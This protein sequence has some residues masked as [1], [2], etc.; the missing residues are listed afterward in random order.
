[1]WLLFV[2]YHLSFSDYIERKLFRFSAWSWMCAVRKS[3]THTGHVISCPFNSLLMKEN[4]P[5]FCCLNLIL[6]HQCIKSSKCKT[7]IHVT[8]GHY[9]S[10][11]WRYL[12]LVLKIGQFFFQ[13]GPLHWRNILLRESG[14]K[15][16][17]GLF[18]P[19]IYPVVVSVVEP[20]CCKWF[21]IDQFP[22]VSF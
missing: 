9:S 2:L 15:M 1:M 7:I 10:C 11:V 13:L 5:Y 21:P 12:H 6:L 18:P 19:L 22:L 16:S 3:N 17:Q 20:Y 8:Q 14:S 4:W